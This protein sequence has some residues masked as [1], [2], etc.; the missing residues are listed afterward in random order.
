MNG[1]RNKSTLDQARVVYL[2]SQIIEKLASRLK[3]AAE[4][5]GITPADELENMEHPF[6][7]N[8]L[9]RKMKAV[10]EILRTGEI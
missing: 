6:E 1:D 2:K 4:K 5:V 9:T 7:D 10:K 8:S 3:L